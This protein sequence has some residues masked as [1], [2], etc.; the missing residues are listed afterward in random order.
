MFF[1]TNLIYLGKN[2]MNRLRE[3]L[4]NSTHVNIFCVI[5]LFILL[6]ST[7]FV[8]HTN[9]FSE[10]VLSGTIDIEEEQ[11]GFI[12][13]GS[14][15]EGTLHYQGV[16]YTFTLKGLKVGGLGISKMSAAGE[17]YNLYNL[18]EFPGTYVAGEYGLS[19][20]GGMGGTV[21]KN[22]NGVY[23]NVHSTIQGVSLNFGVEG[24]AVELKDADV[25]DEEEQ[26]DVNVE[27]EPAA[28]TY[29][30]QSGDTLYEISQKFNVTIAD[31][32]NANNLDSDLIKVG[33]I[34]QI[35]Q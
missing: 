3:Y 16:D 4:S 33:Q 24:I 15:G 19:V 6:C 25:P 22:Q 23:L 5:R 26:E 20:G 27:T 17:V 30:V 29:T 10:N 9:A 13:N 31:I 7:F 35:P 34:L 21:L 2:M 8:L 18:S 12:I 14:I 32:K 1:E 11:I 28:T